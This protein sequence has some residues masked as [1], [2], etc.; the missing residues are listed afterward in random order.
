MDHY[1]ARC[2]QSNH[3]LDSRSKA[4]VLLLHRLPMD[5]RP[6]DLLHVGNQIPY[7]D[8]SQR[9]VWMR[10]RLSCHC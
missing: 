1:L 9:L 3:S 6:L 2:A 5:L 10:R 8:H 7:Q 4:V